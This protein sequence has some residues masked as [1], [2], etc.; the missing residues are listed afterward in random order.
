MP[1]NLLGM[2]TSALNFLFGT[3]LL[4]RAFSGQSLP[5][6]LSSLITTSHVCSLLG[7]KQKNLELHL[8]LISSSCE[9]KTNLM[10]KLK[11]LFFQIQGTM[12]IHIQ[13]CLSVSIPRFMVRTS[14]HRSYRT[15]CSYATPH[16]LRHLLSSPYFN[17]VT[18]RVCFG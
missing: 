13:I 14:H 2:R 3:R 1:P 4:F 6:F 7:T 11:F 12:S 16:S 5:V 9:T 18:R 8:S 17:T 15:V 10:E